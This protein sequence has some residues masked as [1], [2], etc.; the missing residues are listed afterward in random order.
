MQGADEIA[1]TKLDVLS[2]LDKIPVCSAYEIDGVVTDNFP[3]GGE[4]KKAKPV[5]IY[6][7]GWKSDIS[8]CRKFEDLPKAAQEY[9]LYL[10]KVTGAKIRYVSVGADRES[11]I[12]RW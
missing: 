8:G 12:K 5:Y 11:Y 9:V 3:M 6:L 4:L 10:E 2:Y 1:L 7:D